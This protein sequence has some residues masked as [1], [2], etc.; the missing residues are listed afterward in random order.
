MKKVKTND[1]VIVSTYF[2][3]IRKCIH[4]TKE[5]NYSYLNSQLVEENKLLLK[6]NDEKFITGSDYINKKNKILNT[7]P[8]REGELYVDKDSLV[9]ASSCLTEDEDK[10]KEKSLHL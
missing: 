9:L 10:I 2:G 3:S 7:L 5:N 1:I 6:T 4:L 8:T